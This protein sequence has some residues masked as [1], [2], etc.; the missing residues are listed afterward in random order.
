MSVIKIVIHSTLEVSY[1]RL[2]IKYMNYKTHYCNTQRH[3]VIFCVRLLCTKS[4]LASTHRDAR[5]GRPLEMVEI[6][7]DGNKA[8]GDLGSLHHKGRSTL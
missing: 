8:A 1:K 6:N 7:N 3:F 4:I 2:K 5:N